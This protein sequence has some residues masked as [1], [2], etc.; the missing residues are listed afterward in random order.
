MK[1][2]SSHSGSKKIRTLSIG[3]AMFDLFMSMPASAIHDCNN[4]KSFALPLGGKIRVNDVIGACGGGAHN[5][6]VGLARLG[7]AASFSGVVGS[8]QWGE[9]IQNNLEKEGVDTNNLTIIEDE[10]SSFSLILSSPSGERTILSHKSMDR[11]FH[12]VTFDRDA[13]AAVDAIYLN[14]LHESTCVIENDIVDILKS[15]PTTHLTWNP[16]GQQIDGGIGHAG[17]KA[18]LAQCDLLLLNKEEALTFSG[19]ATVDEALKALTAT[20][21]KIVCIT[22]G[23]NGSVASDGTQT[24]S[25]P[26]IPAKVVDTTG[27]GDAFGSAMTWALISGKDLPTAL[28]AGTINASSVVG[29]IGAQEGLLTETQI[30]SKLA[31]S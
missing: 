2:S 17:N 8:D 25:C 1:Q 15:L 5:T 21:A 28:K 29:S 18:L 26:A 13:A 23:G 27:A 7:C 19:C 10:H 14:H 20:G 4:T 11:H 22:D 9:A 31:I 12:D 24:Y 3:G 6:S 16:G 30:Q